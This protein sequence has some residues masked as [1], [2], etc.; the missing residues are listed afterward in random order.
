M[1]QFRGIPLSDQLQ[2]TALVSAFQYTFPRDFQNPG[3][4]HNGWEFVFVKQGSLCIHAEDS[5]YILKTGE[6]VCHRPMEFHA[7]RPNQDNTTAIILCFHCQGEG[8]EQFYRKILQVNRRQK[9]YFNDLVSLSSQFLISKEPLQI[10]QDGGMSRSPSATPAQEQQI[11]NTLELLLLSLMES[12][13]TDRSLRQEMYELN[14]LRKN[15]SS[16]ISAYLEENLHTQV[17]LSDLTEVFPYSVSSI[18]RIFREETGFTVMEYLQQQRIQRACRLLK[19]TDLSVERIASLVGFSS[20]YYF[21]NVFRAKMG[22]T[23][24]AHR[25]EPK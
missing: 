4:Q 21:S 23:P 10:T 11:K 5:A 7:L 13:A 3:E 20:V 12:S 25:R 22:Q 6:L 19:T 15:L 9:L 1:G 2:A 14:S 17:R 24:T 18:K 16:D 8:M